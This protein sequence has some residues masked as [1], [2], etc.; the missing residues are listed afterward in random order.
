MKQKNDT[1]EISTYY[2]YMDRDQ[3]TVYRYQP[4]RLTGRGGWVIAEIMHCQRHERALSKPRLPNLVPR[5]AQGQNFLE[6]F[7]LLLCQ[8]LGIKKVGDGL[9]FICCLLG[10]MLSQGSWD[11]ISRKPSSLLE[12]ILIELDS[13]TIFRF[14]W[15]FQRI[16]WAFQSPQNENSMIS[17]SYFILGLA[18]STL[19]QVTP[20]IHPMVL[21]TNIWTVCH[22][23]KV[24]GFLFL[25]NLF[26]YLF[27]YCTTF[28]LHVWL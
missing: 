14:E 21:H 5:E 6:E 25:E 12:W 10:K 8:S 24:W 16:I 1:A 11:S 9:G 23:P 3:K 15:S 27:I 19:T 4:S 17:D 20:P 7:C 22:T 28:C 18:T 26:I 13:C 2:V